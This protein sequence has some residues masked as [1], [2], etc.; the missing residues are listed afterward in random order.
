MVQVLKKD[1]KEKILIMAKQELLRSDFCT[2]NLRELSRK[3]D[4]SLS[5]IYNYFDNKNAIL[6]AVLEN[7]LQKF[8]EI[9]KKIEK[10]LNTEKKLLYINF[11]KSKTYATKVIDFIIDNKEDLD[12]LCNKTKGS[13]LENFID[14]WAK[15]YAQMEYKSLKLKAKHNKDL[16]KYLPSEFFITNLC[17]FFFGCCKNLV[18]ENLEIKELKN[19]LEEIFAFIYQGWDYYT[20]M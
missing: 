14:N 4:V 8:K 11:D 18:A 20:E 9:D 1:I 5:N 15:N 6:I 2:L 12:I 7:L 10:T 13:S 19:R 17:V 16:L 3:S